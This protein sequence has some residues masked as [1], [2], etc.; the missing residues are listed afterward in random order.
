MVQA[1][2]RCIREQSSKQCDAAA[3]SRFVPLAR[4]LHPRSARLK[5]LFIFLFLFFSPSALFIITLNRRVEKKGVVG[6]GRSETERSVCVCLGDS[7]FF[8]RLSATPHASTLS[9]V[10]LFRPLCV[11]R[12]VS[13]RCITVNG[14]GNCTLNISGLSPS[15]HVKKSA[16]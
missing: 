10:P 14:P 4:A 11:T 9:L 3:G 5:K 7:L 8:R 1:G 16:I 2:R 13:Q 15:K 12:R 6:G